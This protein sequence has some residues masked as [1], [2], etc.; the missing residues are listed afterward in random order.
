[1]PFVQN[2]FHIKS[3]KD[4]ASYGHFNHKSFFLSSAWTLMF[5]TSFPDDTIHFELQLIESTL[6]LMHLGNNNFTVTLL[7]LITS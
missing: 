6:S 4:E 2:Y 3:H 5:S 1:M 7:A